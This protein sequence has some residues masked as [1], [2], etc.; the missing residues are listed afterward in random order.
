[1][2][3]YPSF[4]QVG[5]IVG[6]SVSQTQGQGQ[7]PVGNG[8]ERLVNIP[9]EGV[10]NGSGSGGDAYVERLVKEAGG[11]RLRGVV[12]H[13][14]WRSE[15]QEGEEDGVGWGMPGRRVVRGAGRGVDIRMQEIMGVGGAVS[16]LARHRNRNTARGGRRR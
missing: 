11:G 3:L 15:E 16:A 14:D 10:L 12:V 4:T 5:L 8:R 9:I 1:M 13:V 6:V 7:V 2:G